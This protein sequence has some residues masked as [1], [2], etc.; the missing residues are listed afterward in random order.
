MVEEMREARFTLDLIASTTK[1]NSFTEKELETTY[2]SL[3]FN[4]T[5]MDMEVSITSSITAGNNVFEIVTWNL[6]TNR[7]LNS[8]DRINIRVNWMQDI[9]TFKIYSGYV[10]TIVT[11]VDGQDLK[12][13]LTG[14]LIDDFLMNTIRPKTVSERSYSNVIKTLANLQST[15]Q[16]V[17]IASV[18]CVIPDWENLDH[19]LPYDD[20]QIGKKTVLEILQELKVNFKTELGK[21]VSITYNEQNN[22]VLIA[23]YSDQESYG[24][25]TVLVL[26]DE[27]IFEYRMETVDTTSDESDEELYD[28]TTDTSIEYEYDYEDE[29][30]TTVAP[31]VMVIST[32]GVVGF[33]RNA[34][35]KYNGNYYIASDVIHSFSDSDGYLMEIYANIV[36]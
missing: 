17:G 33:M 16:L 13:T 22:N 12:Y 18:T 9:K 25:I 2:S 29:E 6:P 7:T 20:I 28:D 36:G 26:G 32:T 8:G 24:T 31:T 11:E 21:E 15:L 4:N 10:E 14:S 23:L 5:Q 34:I 3:S 30:D 27:D 19:R 1:I 35:F